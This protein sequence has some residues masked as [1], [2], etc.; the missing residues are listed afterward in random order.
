LARSGPLLP[1]ILVT[2]VALRL[3]VAIYLGDSV[4]P[5][6]DE[7]SYHSLAAR[8]AS[9]QGYTF[10]T[11]WYPFTPPDTPTAHWSFLYTAFL[12]G[13]YKV[14]GHHPL[15]GR[16]AGAVIGGLLLPWL[17]FRLTR[18]VIEDSRPTGDDSEPAS[19]PV[20]LP[21]SI[22][23][24]AAA[25]AA[26]YAYFILFAAQL[27]TETFYICALL[28]SLERSIALARALGEGRRAWPIAAGLGLALAAATLFRQSIL[29]WVA[30]SFAY[31]LCR[32]W[33]VRRLREGIASL[34][35]AGTLI[36]AA[37]L[38][39][40]LRNLRVY[41]GS[42]LLLNSNAGYAMYSAQHP[43]H[44]TNFREYW[45]APLPPELIDLR[46]NEAQW[47]KVLMR[48][49]IG[50]VFQDPLRYLRLSLSRVPDYFEFW[51]TADS[52]L[53]FN[54]GRALSIGLLLPFMLAGIGL[55]H[56]RGGL[57]RFEPQASA[58]LLLFM[59]FYSLLHI[60]TW[61]MSRYRLPVDAVALPFAALCLAV[62]WDA[63]ARRRT[64]QAYS[65]SLG[66]A[67]NNGREA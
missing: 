2:A 59:G 37:V 34:L 19:A 30:L 5:D 31:L 38:P 55:A 27:M 36:A 14:A 41:D 1:I 66:T 33:R 44:G 23:L 60:F 58:F 43:D 40:T 7:T 54:L 39:F 50:Y 64:G 56:T 29:P 21:S 35:L 25:L 24:L 13:I 17:A 10:P 18:Q 51:P 9:G 3:L 46:L 67:R 11:G 52:S 63:V 42:F 57:S 22:P 32:A 62:V 61:A 47:D 45:A 8:L 48:R 6:K 12:A 15:A 4:P 28:W 49:G 26:V 65:A 53:L 20:Q 16:V